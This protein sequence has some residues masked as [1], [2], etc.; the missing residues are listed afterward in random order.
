MHLQFK[1]HYNTQWGQHL[2]IETNSS[3]FAQIPLQYTTDGW[4]QASL[5]TTKLP[6]D[7]TYQY[8]IKDEYG[9]NLRELE[10]GR[11]L[12]TCNTKHRLVL[13]DSWLDSTHPDAALFA[14]AF[15]DVIFRPQKEVKAKSRRSKAGHCLV[16][17]RLLQVRV[18]S[19]CELVVVGNKP[20]LGD[21]DIAKG[22]VLSNTS[23]PWWTGVAPIPHGASV[24]YKYVL[25]DA[26][27]KEVRHWEEGANRTLQLDQEATDHFIKS[28]TYFLYPGGE[29]KG[30]GLALPVFSL[31]TAQSCGV[32]EFTDIQSLVD[33]TKQLGMQMVQILPV[34]DTTSSF[35]WVD[36]YPYSAISVFALHPIYLN[37]DSL[38]QAPAKRTHDKKREALNALSEV[39]Y[40]AVLRYKL[41]AARKVYKK[42]GSKT[43]KSADFEAFFADNA[44]WLRPYA[45]FCY[46]RDQHQTANWLDWPAEDSTYDEKRITQLSDTKSKAY[47]EIAFHYYLQFHLDQQLKGAAEYARS[48]GIILKGDIPIGIDRESADAWAAPHLYNMNGQAGA[49]PDNF[50]KDG[51]NWGF[52]T[53]NWEVMAEDGYQWWKQRFTQLSRY[54]DA[55]RID[56]ILGFFRIWETPYEQMEG[57]M[58]RFQPALPITLNEFWQR[59]IYFDYDRLCRPFI[60]GEVLWHI[61]GDQANYV[62]EHFLEPFHDRLQLKAAYRTQRQ[63]SEALT[64]QQKHLQK[65]LFDLVSNVLFFPESGSAEYFHPRI[66]Q[67]DTLSFQMLDGYTKQQI[68]DLYNDYFYHRQE[69]FWREQGLTKLPAMKAATNMLICGEDLGMVPKCVPSVMEE[70]GILSLEIQRMSKT[71]TE[72]L[73]ERDIPYWS[74]CS[75]GTHDME[76]LRMWWEIIPADVRQRFYNNILGWFGEAPGECHPEIAQAIFQQHLHWKTMWVVFPLQDLLAMDGELRRADAHEERINIPAIKEHYWR[77]RMHLSMEQLLAEDGFNSRVQTMIAE[78]GR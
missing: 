65:G 51:Q 76:T 39:D 28:D 44:Y 34:N 17:F 64:E 6:S 30:S 78:A 24:S 73:L 40:E 19:D 16:H 15:E 22:L 21:W 52:P 55:F 63:I 5:E 14:S 3:K 72:F 60:N 50:A 31:R 49:P 11:L 29:W 43:L 36:S 32:G 56:H 48:Q 4:W 7:F 33:W 41:D 58:G 2:F 57:I 54:F 45:V 35:S 37:L 23:R 47:K 70:L 69:E 18:P 27:T 62:A 20:E 46:L 67:F 13:Q 59:G 10:V 9:N 42:V 71:N 8:V 61:F 74:V 77:Y 68:R 25:R 66:S 12:P 1:I 53:Y 26:T 38:E 75:P